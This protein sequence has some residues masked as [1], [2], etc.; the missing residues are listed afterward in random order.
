[1]VSTAR[2][3]GGSPPL[4]PVPQLRPAPPVFSYSQYHLERLYEEQFERFEIPRS[5]R[6]RLEES[7]RPQYLF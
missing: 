2:H 6:L 1:M 4:T 7:K 5:Q 3:E